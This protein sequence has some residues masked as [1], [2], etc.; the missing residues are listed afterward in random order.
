[1]QTKSNVLLTSACTRSFL[2]KKIYADTSMASAEGVLRLGK[3]LGHKGNSNEVLYKPPSTIIT[4]SSH[5]PVAIFFGGDVQDYPEVML[6]HRDNWRYVEW[7]LLN[8]TSL[9]A[10]KFPTHHTFVVKPKRMALKTFSCYD[11]F[12][13]SDKL[14]APNHQP[15]HHAIKHLMAII[16]GALLALKNPK[17][18]AAC[19]PEDLESHKK[20][21]KEAEL[22]AEEKEASDTESKCS[23]EESSTSLKSNLLTKEKELISDMKDESTEEA[24][25]N[26]ETCDTESDNETILHKDEDESVDYGDV[27]LVGFS[28]GCVVLNQVITELH[29]VKTLPSSENDDVLR[30]MNKVK[31]IFWLDGG[32]CGGSN[33]WITQPSVLTTLG[34]LC[35]INI[36]VHVTPYQVRDEKR[37]WIKKESQAFV[38]QLK[39]NG[40]PVE[41]LLHFEDEIPSLDYHFEV[42]KAF[43]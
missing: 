35:H 38:N 4:K 26:S 2:I 33:T 22:S 13:P 28:K 19:T 7:N 37:P 1:M 17:H 34:S 23:K 24:Q 41:Y 14:G 40:V 16:R 5:V 31:E 29:C 27:T 36:H 20:L 39:R 21:N 8:T 32:H 42:L 3:I 25:I 11:N 30:F 6:A 12:V 18:Q 9:L 10:S 43:K 15:F